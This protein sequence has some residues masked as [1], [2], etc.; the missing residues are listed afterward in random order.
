MKKLM[1]ITLFVTGG[2]AARFNVIYGNNEGNG[3][4]SGK[5]GPGECY[6]QG[7]SLIWFLR[8]GAGHAK[9]WQKP[10]GALLDKYL[11]ALLDTG[12]VDKAVDTAFAG[13]DWDALEAS[14]LD[15]TR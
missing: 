13:V 15:Y 12:D 4:A 2:L 3:N 5:L 10:W 7:W 1:L 14:W 11:I 6:A 9:G 8:T